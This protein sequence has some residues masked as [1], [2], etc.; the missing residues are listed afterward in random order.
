MGIESDD[1]PVRMSKRRVKIIKNRLFL[2][3]QTECAIATTPIL[4]GCLTSANDDVDVHGKD[5]CNIKIEDTF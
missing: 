2:S 4:S 1:P 5:N 3:G